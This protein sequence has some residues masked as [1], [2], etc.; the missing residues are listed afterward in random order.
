MSNS[1]V[2]AFSNNNDGDDD[3]DG[4]VGENCFGNLFFSS[5]REKFDYCLNRMQTRIHRQQWN[6]QQQQQQRNNKNRP[7]TC[8]L[9]F[10]GQVGQHGIGMV[11]YALIGAHCPVGS[12]HIGDGGGGGPE[13]TDSGQQ[14]HYTASH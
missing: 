7:N 10:T 8:A 14:G 12:R 13:Q 5:C 1:R 9:T 11:I 6:K 2:F 4:N 3:D